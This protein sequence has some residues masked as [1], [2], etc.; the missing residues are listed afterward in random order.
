MN[1]DINVYHV[2]QENEIKFL[3]QVQTRKPR[4]ERKNSEKDLQN[5]FLVNLVVKR[6]QK[7]LL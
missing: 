5:C 6:K 1:K 4:P 2:N 3:K 7:S